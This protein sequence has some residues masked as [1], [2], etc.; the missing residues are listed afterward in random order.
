MKA[1][2]PLSGLQAFI[3]AKNEAA[4][5]LRGV[6]VLEAAGAT[7]TVLDSGST[8]E[9]RTLLEEHSAARFVHYD[10]KNHAHA[11][12]DILLRLAKPGVA[13]IFDADMRLTKQLT[14]ELRGVLVR[15]DWDVVLAPVEWW[16]EGQPI[17]H[18]SMYP[19]KAFL[20]Q[21]GRAWMEPRGH[22][23]GLVSGARVLQTKA[24]LIHDDRKGLMAFLQSQVRYAGNMLARGDNGQQGW[25]DWIR[26]HTPLMTL[27]VV[28]HILLIKRGFLDGKPA[29][30]YALDRLVAETI[31]LREA[32][33]KRSRR[34]DGE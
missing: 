16:C 32:I 11:Y 33:A 26:T 27:S 22:G 10:Y 13:A 14:E 3:L 4:N 5:I 31:F 34:K 25:R 19:P 2:V 15:K 17:P 1:Q 12:S 9:T 18:A 30:I 29:L 28:P 6:L 24:K 8:D 23:E 21:T 7:V 20:F